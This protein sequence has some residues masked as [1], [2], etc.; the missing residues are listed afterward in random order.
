M[1]KTIAEKLK[2]LASQYNTKTFIDADPIRFPHRF[3]KQTDIEISA[4]LS[5]WIAYGR[6]EM[7]IAKLEWL[8]KMIGESPTDW[9][10]SESYQQLPFPSDGNR[11]TFYRFYTFNDLRQLC[12]RLHF[13]YEH[14]DTMEKALLKQS[15]RDLLGKV[16]QSF[17]G[18][19]GIPDRTS[20]SA[21][22]RL[23]MF[24]RWMVRQ[25]GIVDFGLWKSF[26][27]KDLIIPLDTH[28]FQMA[29]QLAL[30][31]R[32]TADKT[33]ALEITQQLR[34]VFPDDPCLGDFALFGYGIDS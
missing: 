13:I 1:N 12:E 22:K 10:Q 19:C 31:S 11:G 20:K 32:N 8:H 15:E 25:D 17:E 23:A 26:S 14:E 4:F 27:P 7:I 18:V 5:A 30:T 3:S 28:V 24:L 33:T 2:Q 21:C 16:Q 6:R 34:K 29:K 9:I